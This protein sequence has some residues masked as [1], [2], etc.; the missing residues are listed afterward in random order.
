MYEEKK[1]VIAF[2][3][4]F[5]LAAK[6]C[7]SYADAASAVPVFSIDSNQLYSKSGTPPM[8]D[9]VSTWMGKKVDKIKK[10]RKEEK[11][12]AVISVKVL[13]R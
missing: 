5:L 12:C 6:V 13:F 1:N 2:F 3:P 11:S 10:K 8:V 9:R 7:T 4:H